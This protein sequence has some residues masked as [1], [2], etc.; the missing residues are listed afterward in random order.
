MTSPDYIPFLNSK[1]DCEMFKKHFANAKL[2][3]ITLDRIE[4]IQTPT[5]MDQCWVD[6]G[7]DGFTQ[8]PAGR[9]DKWVDFVKQFGD[10]DF[11]RDTAF[12]QK[13]SEAKLRPLV[14]KMLDMAS[15][16]KPGFLS[17]PQFP[18][19]DGPTN[20]KINRLLADIAA[21]WRTKS[22]SKAKFILP[23]IFTNQNQLVGKTERAP[24]VRL[25][26]TLIAR[27][28]AEGYW[29]VDCSLD[30][31]KGIGNYDKER[32][33]SIVNFFTELNELKLCALRVAGPYWGLNL[34]L[35]ARGLAT[36]FAIGLGSTYNHHIS[37]GFARKT[38]VRIAI[39]SLRRW[40]IAN[41][42]LEVWLGH[43]AAKLSPGSPERQELDGLK[44]ALGKLQQGDAGKRQIAEVYRNWISK[45]EAISPSGRALAL[46]QDLSTAFVTGRNLPDLP[47]DEGTARRPERVAQQLMLNCL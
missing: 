1:G 27:A 35:W 16:K 5:S 42:E 15:A 34:V 23:L 12:L 3:R 25:A 44:L 19:I 6:V 47:S 9:G 37:G 14:T 26:A 18:H 28:G 11:L 39:A 21:D 17:V 8:P 2:C 24:K 32:F 38:K 36:H 4:F 22:G 10:T 33:P 13:P 40:V 43:A 41:N 31:Q 30:D 46:Y 29:S 20:N 45:I 7:F